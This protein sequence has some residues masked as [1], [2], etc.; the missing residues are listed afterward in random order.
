VAGDDAEAKETVLQLAHD[1]GLVAIGAGPL[2]R[3]RQLEGLGFLGMTLQQPLG[4]NFR[5]AWKLVSSSALEC[6]S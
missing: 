3:E 4:T 6:L 2:R 5:N 1:S